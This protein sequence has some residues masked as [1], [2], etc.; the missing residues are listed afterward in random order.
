V[1]ADYRCPSVLG[2]SAS[3]AANAARFGKQAISV[4]TAPLRQR[5]LPLLDHPV[6]LAPELQRVCKL[7]T[8]HFSLLRVI[9]ESEG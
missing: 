6:S 1:V 5:G 3:V 9:T 7:F 4:F 8:L 2:G